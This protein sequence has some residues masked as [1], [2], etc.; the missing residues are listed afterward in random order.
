[1]LLPFK[2]QVLTE[3]LLGRWDLF[4]LQ[5]CFFLSEEVDAHSAWAPQAGLED[6]FSHGSSPRWASHT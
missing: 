2:G 6:K 4:G 1:M 3:E 5:F